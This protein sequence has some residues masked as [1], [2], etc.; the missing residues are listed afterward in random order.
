L[1]ELIAPAKPPAHG[2]L[3]EVMKGEVQ[4]SLGFIQP[5]I[6]RDLFGG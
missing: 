4:F 6:S 3:D 5:C 2:F 1:R